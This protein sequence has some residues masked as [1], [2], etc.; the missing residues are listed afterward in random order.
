MSFII[1]IAIILL[2]QF[3]K[4]L[5]LNH[6]TDISTIPLWEGVFHLTYRENTGAAFSIF[7]D[8][9]LFLKI[10]TSIFV[11][12]LLIFL[13]KHVRSEKKFTLKALSLSFII[14]GAVGNLIDRLRFNFVVDFFDFRL[15]NFAVFNVADS[16]IVIGSILLIIILMLDPSDKIF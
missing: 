12:L 7:T 5:V 6:L 3:S 8:M 15:I 16:F 14:G 2:D 4:Y 9:Q 11:V 1:I 13:I 10:I